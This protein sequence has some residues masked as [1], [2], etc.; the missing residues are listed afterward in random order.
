M[1]AMLG[2]SL[3][4]VTS[5]PLPGEP[6]DLVDQASAAQLL[7]QAVTKTFPSGPEPDEETGGIRT[8]CYYQA[9]TRGLVVTQVVF[10]S[11]AEAR[12]A[13][14][15]ELMEDQ[16]DSEEM[17]I[18]E[19]SGLG[20]KAFWAYTDKTA[21]YVVVKGAKVVALSLGGMPKEPTSYQATLRA[22]TRAVA[23]RL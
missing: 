15:R 18:K 17:T 7:G 14:T 4:I 12:Q 10:K 16:M 2:L 9:G 23:A 11:A 3:A 21:Q 8:I 22:A 20:D 5:G 6:C 19:E 13:T 1:L